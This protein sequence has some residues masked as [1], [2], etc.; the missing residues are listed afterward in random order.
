MTV[1][2][3]TGPSTIPRISYRRGPR[4]I[5]KYSIKTKSH[6]QTRFQAKENNNQRVWSMI[7]VFRQFYEI[8]T[9][10]WLL[11]ITKSRFNYD[12]INFNIHAFVVINLLCIENISYFSDIVC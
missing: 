9:N 1:P 12:F 3:E 10:T 7:S 5:S 2:Y 6:N 8:V 11:I 4:R